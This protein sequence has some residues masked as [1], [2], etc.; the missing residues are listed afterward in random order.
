MSGNPERCS[1]WPPLLPNC[2]DLTLQ[3]LDETHINN[4]VDI[5]LGHFRV[6]LAKKIFDHL[7]AGDG[8]RG[9]FLIDFR[10]T[11]PGF[12]QGFGIVY[13]HEPSQTAYASFSIAFERT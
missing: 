5:Q 11:A 13:F 10:L 8:R 12:I 1:N 9:H 3:S 4:L 7:D 2:S 6:G